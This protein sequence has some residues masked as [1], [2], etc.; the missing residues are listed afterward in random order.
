MSIENN[1]I[2]LFILGFFLPLTCADKFYHQSRTE[3]AQNQH[4]NSPKAP[5]FPP[6]PLLGCRFSSLLDFLL[7]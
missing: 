2:W 4:N 7:N 6:A 1:Q 3:S 5:H